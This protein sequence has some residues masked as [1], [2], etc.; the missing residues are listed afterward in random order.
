M[1]GE[2]GS[3]R[4]LFG[5]S[6]QVMRLAVL[7]GLGLLGGRLYGQAA[8]KPASAPDCTDENLELTLR[9]YRAP[10]S[11]H[12]LVLNYRNTGDSPCTLREFRQQNGRPSYIRN[13]NHVEVPSPRTVLA[14]HGVAHSS[15]RWQTEPVAGQACPNDG[16]HLR[17]ILVGTP[18]GTLVLTS[19]TLLPSVCSELQDDTDYHAGAFVPEWEPS[20]DLAPPISTAPT[21]AVAKQTYFENERLSLHV[22]L[23][24]RTANNPVCPILLQTA[25]DEH[26]GIRIDEVLN[27]E[28]PDFSNVP[29]LDPV[30][31]LAL[32]C[33]HRYPN[34]GP[35]NEFNF[36]VPLGSGMIWTG[37]GMHRFGFIQLS[38]F[39]ED[40][41][42]RQVSSNEVAVDVESAVN[43]PRTWGKAEKGVRVDL[44][45]DKLTYALG[46]EIPLH[47]ATEDLAAEFPVYGRPFGSYSMGDT[48][49]LDE[50][51][52]VAVVVEDEHGPIKPVEMGWSGSGRP[53]PCP[54][55]YPQGVVVPKEEPLSFTGLLPTKPGTYRIL[56]KWSPYRSAS[57]ASCEEVQ[58]DPDSFRD[59]GADTAGKLAP[60]VTVSSTPI[61]IH[62]GEAVSSNNKPQP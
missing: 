43:I 35:D 49:M 48:S 37:L 57:G 7:V 39:A 10:A 3:R 46:E 18:N 33:H 23:N 11:T 58:R 26:G 54:K 32:A 17:F 61:T 34:P 12:V 25:R 50:G 38:G 41:E 21:V 14:G 13:S 60:F 53:I 22:T 24:D 62:I 8:G 29:N 28:S 42:F 51:W 31:R 15:F 19:R 16:M 40:C 52:S 2:I 47:I 55:P 59:T 44:T 30:G 9:A 4:V 6:R 1:F 36:Y 27:P 56:V 5:S 45:L 20:H